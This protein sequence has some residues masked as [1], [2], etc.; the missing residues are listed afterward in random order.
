M[1]L[2]PEE[3]RSS[4]QLAQLIERIVQREEGALDQF[5]TLTSKRVYSIALKILGQ[6]DLA[7]EATLE[8]Y[9]KVW[10]LAGEY[11]QD[12]GTITI[13][14]NLITR[15]ICLNLLR[16]EKRI[17]RREQYDEVALHGSS[18][19]A[20]QEQALER[21]QQIHQI[22]VLMTQLSPDQRKVVDAAYFKGLS[23]AQIAVE[24]SMP[25]GSVKTRMRAALVYLR[26][27]LLGDERKA[28]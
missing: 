8:V 28:L 16:R 18:V 14:L 2:W 11:Q 20:T 13:W 25:L 15:S 10:R 12:R 26:Q 4:E 19:P 3:A 22:Q 5:Y 6:E 1:S 24:L 23:Q 27:G 17:T 9:T 21:D 7:E